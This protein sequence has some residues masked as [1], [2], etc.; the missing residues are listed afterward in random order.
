MCPREK[1][2]PRAEPWVHRSVESQGK[3][4]VRVWCQKQKGHHVRADGAGALVVPASG[5]QGGPEPDWGVFGKEG[6]WM[7]F[8]EHPL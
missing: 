3:M 6:L 1:R 7:A 8:P 4:A 5:D 2:G